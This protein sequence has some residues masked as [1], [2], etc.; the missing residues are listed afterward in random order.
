MPSKNHPYEPLWRNKYRMRRLLKGFSDKNIYR[1]VVLYIN[2][3]WPITRLILRLFPKTGVNYNRYLLFDDYA[4]R[5]PGMDPKHFKAFAM[6]D[7]HDFLAPDYDTPAKE[8]EFRSW[9]AEA[10]L[11][12][13]DVHPGY[14]GLEGRGTKA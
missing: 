4:P 1:F 8:E 12:D 14:N 6:L 7:I 3:L 13:I 5:L 10:G 11:K 9:H 2:G